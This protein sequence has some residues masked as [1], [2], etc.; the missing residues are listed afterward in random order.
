MRRHAKACE[1]MRISR[2]IGSRKGFTLIELVVVL[3]VIAVL[4]SLALPAVQSVREAARNTSCRN[5]LKQLGLAAQNHQSSFGA[6]PANGWGYAWLGDSRAG[7][8]ADQPGG[9][10]FQLLPKLGRNDLFEL[11]NYS[12]ANSADRR[13]QLAVS[14][15]EQVRCPARPGS[16]IQPQSQA[17]RYRLS[18]RAEFVARTDYAINEGDWISNS[19]EGP[20]DQ[21]RTSVS[22]YGWIDASKVTGISWER[23]AA[24]LGRISDGTSATIFCGE[25]LVSQTGYDTGLDRGYD[26]S[27]FSGVDIDLSRWT[28]AP[29]ASDRD[30]LGPLERRFGSAHRGGA[31]MVFCDG[32]VTTLSYSVNAEVFRAM[33]NRR[34]G[35]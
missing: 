25:K 22:Q 21:S 16:F 11:A 35:K 10:I 18:S 34:D 29:P 30:Y 23:G 19:G 2:R 7:F 8:G 31:N 32:S 28:N 33:G 15:L 14:G 27:P 4:I 3:S 20:V 9:W 26:Q 1:G 6:L 17:F 13:R 5:N 12:G 24:R